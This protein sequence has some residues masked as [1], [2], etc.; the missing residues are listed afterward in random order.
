MNIKIAI[1]H[2]AWAGETRR[3]NYKRLVQEL[4][5]DY[6]HVSEAQEHATVWA[7]D[8]WTEASK[9][10]RNATVILNDD[11]EVCPDFRQVL[12]AMTLNDEG[13]GV[14][15]HLGL[16]TTFPEL[17]TF[18]NLPSWIRS[19]WYTGPAMCLTPLWARHLLRFWDSHPE[20]HDAN[21][22]MVG[23]YAAYEARKPYYHPIPSPVKHRTDIRSTLGYDGHAHRLTL[24]PWDDL[25]FAGLDLTDP[26]TWRPP[27]L[28]V[29]WM[30]DA[31]LR[32]LRKC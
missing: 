20:L 10:D 6:V 27:R 5:P 13:S 16:H 14:G 26:E 22:D 21:E 8:L 31:T 24:C 17:E 15:A 1:G 11:V 7:R 25:R 28:E 23:I 4:K 19:Y 18:P 3:E 12:W 32:I 2:A 30:R 9:D 29:P